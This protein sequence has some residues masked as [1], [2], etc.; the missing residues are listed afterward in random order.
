MKQQKRRRR[1]APT[2]VPQLN[3]S[4]THHRSGMLLILVLGAIAMAPYLVFF[5][6][7]NNSI[8]STSE[9]PQQGSSTTTSNL[10]TAAKPIPLHP[11]N[12]TVALKEK[13]WAIELRTP[14]LNASWLY[15]K[16]NGHFE[17]T[18]NSLA[19]A[20][21]DQPQ[22]KICSFQPLKQKKSWRTKFF[23]GTPEG[24]FLN[25]VPKTASTVMTTV[26][27]RISRRLGA[28]IIALESTRSNNNKESP[29]EKAKNNSNFCARYDEHCGGRAPAYFGDRNLDHSFLWGS[30]RD[31]ASRAMS[32]IFFDFSKIEKDAREAGE[33][34]I[35]R[36]L[37]ENRNRHSGTVS[38]GQGGFQIQYLALE[39]MEEWSTW[40]KS[41][42]T[43]VQR[44]GR[45]QER[46]K[47]IV[48]DY[49]FLAL[50]ERLGESLVALQ[51]LLGLPPGDILSV[52]TKISGESYYF[53]P[54]KRG[55]KKGKCVVIQKSF[56]TPAIEEYLTSDEWYA[57]NYG[58][59]VLYAAANKSLDITIERL[60]QDRFDRSLQQY[61]YAQ[62]LVA[63]RCRDEIFLPCSATGE[64]Q[65]RLAEQN[66]YNKDQGCGHKC[67]DEIS[68]EQGW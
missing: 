65:V 33:E 15:Q 68:L 27:I 44:P 14:Y 10:P 20:Y 59:Y 6:S 40:S 30:L 5:E 7:I 64:P 66:C 1:Q 4:T 49:D 62:N 54:F 21:N 2:V 53:Q 22:K 25:K 32:R 29:S 50:T 48:N 58:D 57:A 55:G 24:L 19:R 52:S 42:P 12:G 18:G 9:Q 28:R 38:S 3:S 56:R 13:G 11:P 23:A 35:L 61:R 46:V 8:A 60:G 67:I 36:Q 34:E 41:Y 37:K 39:D 43:L 26:N 63:E 31:P 45:L 16:N 17:Q 47:K 51:L